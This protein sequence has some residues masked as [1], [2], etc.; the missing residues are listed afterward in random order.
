MQNIEQYKEIKNVFFSFNLKF[1]KISLSSVL[2]NKILL[3]VSQCSVIKLQRY[4]DALNDC[5]TVLSMDYRNVKALLRRA[6]S[7]EHLGNTHEV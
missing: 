3:I 5:N 6:L 1:I 7:L 4:E 2:F